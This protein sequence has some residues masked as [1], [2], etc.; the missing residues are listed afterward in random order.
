M[1]RRKVTAHKQR[2]QTLPSTHMSWVQVRL[3]RLHEDIP[4]N[5]QELLAVACVWQ[6]CHLSCCCV[7]RL[8]PWFHCPDEVHYLNIVTKSRGKGKIF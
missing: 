5:L 4:P 6:H 8:V 7:E 2:Q 1:N 3:H